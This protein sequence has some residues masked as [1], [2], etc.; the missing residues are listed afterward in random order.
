MPEDKVRQVIEDIREADMVLVGIGEEMDLHKKLRSDERYIKTSETLG[1]KCL[2]PYIEKIMLKEF[3]EKN[4]GVYAD[5]E[6][7]LDKKNYF[8]VSLCKDGA[9]TGAGLNQ[10]RIVEPCGAYKRL[11]CANGCSKE[12]YEISN[13]FLEKVE[14]DLNSGN[15]LS[16]AEIPTCPHCGKPLVFNN[17]DAD[18]YVE[19]GYL[20]KW[21]IYQKW[22]QGSLNKKLCILELGVGMKYPTVVRW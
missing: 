16:S 14:I 7:C 19:E 20:D 3:E 22:L 13:A 8:I 21:E 6:K 17:I 15:S 10:D 4:R 5:L 9:I 1:E 12:L 18:N 11:Q 2:L